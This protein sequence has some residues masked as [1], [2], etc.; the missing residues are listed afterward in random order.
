MH[1]RFSRE[2]E[3]SRL[4]ELTTQAGSDISNPN[5]IPEELQPIIFACAA[6]GTGSGA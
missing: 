2:I 3:F 4:V 6:A 1:D 5:D